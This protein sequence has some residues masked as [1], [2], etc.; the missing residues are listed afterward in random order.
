VGKAIYD[1][2]LLECYF[3]KALYKI[4]LG[5]KLTFKDLEDYDAE[6]YKNLKWALEND[7]E[8]ALDE[9]FTIEDAYFG[10][11]QVTELKAGGKLISVTNENKHEYIE[12]LCYFKLFKSMKAQINA[13]MKGFYELIPRELL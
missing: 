4:L 13:F 6:Y 7:I 2:C 12:L 10:Q 9:T 5:E 11:R 8:G 1:G 3:V